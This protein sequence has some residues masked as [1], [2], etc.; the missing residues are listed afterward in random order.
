MFEAVIQVP[1]VNTCKQG[2]FQTSLGHVEL[3]RGQSRILGQAIK[4][5][6]NDVS[7][8]VVGV[9]TFGRRRC[10]VV[11]RRAPDVVAWNLIILS[12][13][14]I[15]ILTPGLRLGKPNMGLKKTWIN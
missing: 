2:Q 5:N 15:S 13:Q 11:N 1:H 7:I 14:N 6:H 3:R 9:G 10:H 12:L 8:H 4:S